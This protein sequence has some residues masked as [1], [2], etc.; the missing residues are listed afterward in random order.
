MSLL[1]IVV[2]GGLAQVLI[3]L[4]GW[5]VAT[6]IAIVLSR[7]LVCVNPSHRGG[8]LMPGVVEAAI[9]IILIAP[10]FLLVPA[11]FFGLGELGAMKNQGLYLV[12]AERKEALVLSVI[13][14]R[15]HGGT[16][17]PEAANIHLT[18]RQKKVQGGFGLSRDSLLDCLVLDV[19]LRTFLFSLSADGWL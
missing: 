12:T 7:G 19:F 6:S 10:T 13:L 16:V 15:F 18:N 4:T 3:F 2:I 1:V 17:A 5:P 9:A 8:D 11:R 14:G